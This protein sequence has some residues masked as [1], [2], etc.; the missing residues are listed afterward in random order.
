MPNTTYDSNVQS[1]AADGQSA[2]AEILITLNKFLSGLIPKGQA[3]L[4]EIARCWVA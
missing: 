1:S 2:A 4:Q 3:Q